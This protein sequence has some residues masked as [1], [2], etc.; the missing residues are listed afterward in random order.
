MTRFQGPLEDMR[1]ATP[2]YCTKDMMNRSRS[3]KA[4]VLLVSALAAGPALAGCA[5]G[6]GSIGAPGSGGNT[7]TGDAGPGAGGS[8]N[9]GAADRRDAADVASGS[10]G[11]DAAVSDVASRDIYIAERPA[12][13]PGILLHVT[14]GC[15]FDLW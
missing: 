1:A 2:T 5:A 9:G 12:D 13:A 15:P 6:S 7:G 4:E 11:A 8:G 10:G 3:W 14:N